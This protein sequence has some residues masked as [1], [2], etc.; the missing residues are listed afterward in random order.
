MFGTLIHISLTD[1]MGLVENILPMQSRN[2]AT[3][4]KDILM[5]DISDGR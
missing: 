3:G 4:P 1:L 2:T 5:F